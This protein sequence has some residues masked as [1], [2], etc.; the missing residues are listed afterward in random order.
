MQ[1]K[2]TLS[3]LIS[4]LLMSFLL[5]CCG[6]GSGSGSGGNTLTPTITGATST[7]FSI[8]N[9]GGSVGEVVSVPVT[10]NYNSATRAVACTISYTPSIAAPGESGN[11]SI[12]DAAAT[13]GSD[14]ACRRK[15]A[16][17]S[18]TLLFV[19][20]N[21]GKTTTMATIPFKVISVGTTAL[22][23]TNV[24]AYDSNMQPLAQTVK[25][26]NGQITVR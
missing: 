3:V 23:V 12:R 8:G 18:V 24:A 15:W 26:K 4:F 14:V 5:L 9:G 21:T 7:G 22:T 6:C 25:T 20:G 11:G 13:V 17:G 16:N 2:M 10:L 19:C 1:V